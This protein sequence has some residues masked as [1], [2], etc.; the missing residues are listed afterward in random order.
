[1][2]AS[3]TAI[4]TALEFANVAMAV[5][6]V[7]GLQMPVWPKIQVIALFALRLLSVYATCIQDLHADD[8]RASIIAPNITRLRY[9]QI[10]LFAADWSYARVPLQIVNQITLHL[11]IILAT[12]PCAKPFLTVSSSIVCISDRTELTELRYLSLERCTCLLNL[13][14]TG[15]QPQGLHSSM[16]SQPARRSLSCLSGSDTDARQCAGE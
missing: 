3:Q 4:M 2:Y 1:M 7:W 11:S 12:V 5:V 10:A 14:W 15:C 8:D 9:L 6:T 16:P 13:R